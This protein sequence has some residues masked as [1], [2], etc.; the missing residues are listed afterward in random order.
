MNTRVTNLT[1]R[2]GGTVITDTTATTPPANEIFHAI[3]VIEEAVVAAIAGNL[4]NISGLV[5]KTLPAGLIIYGQITSIT[6]TSGTVIAYV[7]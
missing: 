5:G 6:L 3:E 7:G 4:T 1:G 2:Q